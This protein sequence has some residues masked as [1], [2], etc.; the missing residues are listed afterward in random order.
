[1]SSLYSTQLRVALIVL[2]LNAPF[3]C[4][5][6][7]Q[8]QLASDYEGKVLTLRHFYAGGHLKFH[9]DGTLEGDSAIA[10]CT[11]DG[12]LLVNEVKLQ[13][14]SLVIR[15]RRIILLFDSKSK[16]FHDAL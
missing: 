6:N 4:S 2:L 15:G 8:D 9:A 7:I 3:A 11:V 5:T 14:R 12:Q 16:T 1:M 13:K 10:P